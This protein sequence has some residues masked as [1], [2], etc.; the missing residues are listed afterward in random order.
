ML[1]SIDPFSSIVA[2]LVEKLQ[3]GIAAAAAWSFI[4]MFVDCDRFPSVEFLFVLVICC[5]FAFPYSI[6]SQFWTRLFFPRSLTI[7]V[8]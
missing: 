5:S 6:L 3:F 8:L 2:V 7:F 4:S 1:R